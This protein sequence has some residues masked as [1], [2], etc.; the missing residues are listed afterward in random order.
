MSAIQPLWAVA[1]PA[2]SAD[3]LIVSL[4]DVRRIAAS[5]DLNSR[6]LLDVRRPRGMHE[7]DSEYPSQ[8]QVTYNQDVAFGNDFAQFRSVGYVGAGNAGV[9]QAVGV[10]ADPAAARAA[11]ERV[12]ADLT[13]CAGLNVPNYTFTTRQPDPSTIQRCAENQCSVAYRVKSSVLVNV[14]VVHFPQTAEQI[15]NSVLQTISDRIT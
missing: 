3:S 5:P 4:D 12:V 14:S 11:F 2:L 6:N 9:T 8:C 7:Y 1:D 13:A 10:Y 15:A